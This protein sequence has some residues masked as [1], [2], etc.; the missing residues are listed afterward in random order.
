M[1]H[2]RIHL[3]IDTDTE[4]TT[5][6][7]S[8][9]FCLPSCFTPTAATSSSF[10]TLDSPTGLSRLP[11]ALAS[12]IADIGGRHRHHHHHR[13]PFL[14]GG[15]RRNQSADFQYDAMSYARNFDDG[16]DEALG[17]ADPEYRCRDFVA[18]LPASPPPAVGVPPERS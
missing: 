13:K 2:R 12:W 4:T 18:R 15:R 3:S 8:K 9:T 6:P 1:A 16:E 11:P 7:K 14:G 5:S 17:P 10:K